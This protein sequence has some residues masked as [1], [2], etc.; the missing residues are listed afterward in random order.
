MIRNG[1]TPRTSISEGR[2]SWSRSQPAA[3]AKLKGKGVCWGTLGQTTV[4]SQ[5]SKAF[6]VLLQRRWHLQAH[7]SH[8]PNRFLVCWLADWFGSQPFAYLASP[9]RLPSIFFSD[10]FLSIPTFLSLFAWVASF[11]WAFT[12]DVGLVHSIRPACQG[13]TSF[14]TFSLRFLGFTFVGGVQR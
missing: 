4:T 9:K 6:Q 14:A 1:D 3:A 10:T 13:N 12:N 7:L 2:G 5:T 8:S 11:V